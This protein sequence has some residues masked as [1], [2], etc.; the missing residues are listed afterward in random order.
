VIA[1]LAIIAPL[2]AA[3]QWERDKEDIRRRGL[4]GDMV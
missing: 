1:L 4:Y 2:E 3:R